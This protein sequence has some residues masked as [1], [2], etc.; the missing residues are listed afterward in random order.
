MIIVKI[1]LIGIVGVVFA[2]FFKQFRPEYSMLLGIFLSILFFYIVIQR[3]GYVMKLINEL[4]GYMK[5]QVEFVDILVKMLGISYITELSAGICKD[6]GYQS[7]ATQIVILGKLTMITMG[8]SILLSL[9]K[10]INIGI[11]M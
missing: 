11:G 2:N 10:M 8:S 1:S 4:F 6:A 3:I 5:G 9:I 7:I